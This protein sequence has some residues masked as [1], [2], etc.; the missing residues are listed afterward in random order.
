MLYSAQN[1]DE[2]IRG[3]IFVHKKGSHMNCAICSSSIPAGLS[4]C[5]ECGA[6]VSYSIS[7]DEFLANDKTI[8]QP[9]LSTQATP[10]G[11]RLRE[12]SWVPPLNTAPFQEIKPS[13]SALIMKRGFIL[14]G[15]LVIL[16]IVA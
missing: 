7:D 3:I 16:L 14:F 10:Q 9:P 1:R 4:E 8:T 12:A 2:A 13:R 15:I 5:P 11:P 6:P